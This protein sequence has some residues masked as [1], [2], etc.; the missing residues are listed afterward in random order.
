[1]R[2]KSVKKPRT[3]LCDVYR[4]IQK[5]FSRISQKLT[6]IFGIF[7]LLKSKAIYYIKFEIPIWI[8]THMGS[9][10]VYSG[11]VTLDNKICVRQGEYGK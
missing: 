6:N 5:I 2:T 3:L 7:H 9:F 4:I 1:M 10:C 11:T 8:N